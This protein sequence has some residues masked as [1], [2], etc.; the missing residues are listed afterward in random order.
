MARCG[1]GFVALS[2]VAFFVLVSTGAKS[3]THAQAGTILVSGAPDRT[4]ARPLTGAQLR[5]DVFVFLRPSVKD[6]KRVR[7]Y[8]DDARAKGRPLRITRR[9]PFDLAGQARGGAARPLVVDVL[10]GGKHVVTAVMELADGK[11]RIVNA[12]FTAL[13]RYLAPTGTDTG[14]CTLPRPCKSLARAL[15]VS[16]VG[17]VVEMAGGFYGC[18]TLSGS[19]EVTFRAAAGT[20]P[21]IACPNTPDGSGASLYLNGVSNLTLESVWV[22]GVEFNGGSRITFRNVH[23]TCQDSAPFQLWQGQCNAKLEGNA[24]DFSMIGGEVGPTWDDEAASAPGNSRLFGDRLL[25][26]GVTFNENERAEGSH[27][28]CLMIRGGN[29]VT[30]RNSRFPRCN[31]FS[32]F[33]TYWDFTPTP[34][35]SNV[36]L[37]NNVFL[38]SASG[39]YAVMFA[40]HIP[41]LR[42]VAFRY[43]TSVGPVSFAAQT[44]ENVSIVGNLMPAQS[45]VQGARY[46]YNVVQDGAGARRCG[47][48]DRIVTGETFKADRLGIAANGHLLRGSRAIGA[49]DPKDFPPRDI[50]GDRRPIG[51][52]PDAGADEF[53]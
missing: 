50:D 7:F 52:T 37:E 34:P 20:R 45:C 25:L 19:K 6:I 23:V 39:T 47:S 26:N 40:D 12:S 42:N 35:P 10:P 33:F 22:S 14:A 29:G 17:E 2:A 41:H 13:R 27:T 31:V 32:I 5:G 48:T 15:A 8:L 43:N 4:G 21:W 18:E 51:K 38:S 28:E 46:A 44:L 30:I 16:A 1:R 53:R 24:S 36:T 9:E 11:E 3:E 49:G